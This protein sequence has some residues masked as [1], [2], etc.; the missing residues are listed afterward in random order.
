MTTPSQ[1]V[2]PFFHFGLP[3]P[4]GPYVVA[5]DTPG[6][7]WLRGIVRDGAGDPVPDALIETWQADPAGRYHHPDDPRGP[8]E[9]GAPSYTREVN[10]VPL[11]SA[12]P[13]R[14]F[15]RCG[16]D[17]AGRY[18]IWTVKP[19]AVPAPGGGQ[20][21][22]HLAVAVFARGL[23]HRLVTRVYFADEG[24]ANGLDPVLASMAD[25]AARATLVAAVAEDG[26][27]FDIWLQGEH[28]TTFFRV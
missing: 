22:P 5:A 28:E 9:A 12:G 18:A 17:E 6:G 16:T 11:L 13:W 3:W 27:R 15:G 24:A 20:Q 21:A 23:L 26:Y 10:K 14:G 19:G 4:Q 1:T 8:A 25:P 7:V 2:G